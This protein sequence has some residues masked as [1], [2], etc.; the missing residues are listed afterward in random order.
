MIFWKLLKYNLVY[1]IVERQREK[2]EG[3]LFCQN[4]HLALIRNI[5]E[6]MLPTVTF[7]PKCYSILHESVNLLQCH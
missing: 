3:H 5:P 6:Q 7:L 1:P 2:K 4:T